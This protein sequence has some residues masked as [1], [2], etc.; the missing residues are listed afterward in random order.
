MPK[1]PVSKWLLGKIEQRE[2]ISSNGFSLLIFK[3]EH[4]KIY[5]DNKCDSNTCPSKL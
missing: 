2:I 1:L 5:G 4:R 3:N